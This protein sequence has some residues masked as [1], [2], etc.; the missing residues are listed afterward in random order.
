MNY[1]LDSYLRTFPIIIDAVLFIDL[2]QSLEFMVLPITTCGKCEFSLRWPYFW[3]H[4]GTTMRSWLKRYPLFIMNNC[5]Q[6]KWQPV[7][8]ALY[9]ILNQWRLFGARAGYELYHELLL[10]LFV[11]I[12]VP[13][14]FLLQRCIY[15]GR[16]TRAYILK[17]KVR[18]SL[19]I[20]WGS[21]L[22]MVSSFKLR[23]HFFKYI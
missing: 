14:A 8:G 16:T 7:G 12:R 4:K 19:P 23:I 22:G 18:S 2:F 9:A 15:Y 3:A 11:A 6:C 21:L 5:V 1:E 10:A 20:Q 17:K 13:V